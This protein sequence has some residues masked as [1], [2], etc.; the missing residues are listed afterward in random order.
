MAT[1]VIDV[2]E[3]QGVIDWEKVKKSGIKGAI[4]RC[5]Y[6]SDDTSQDDKQ[7]KRNVSECERLGIPYGVYLYSYA[8]NTEMARSEAQHAIRLCKGRK[9]AYPLFFDTEEKGTEN[10]SAACA[11]VFC[12]AVKKAGFTPGIYASRSWWQSYLKGVTGYAKWVAEWGVNKCSITCD[13]WQYA[14]NGKVSGINGAVDMNYCY[15]DYSKKTTSK[16]PTAKTETVKGTAAKVLEV[17]KTQIGQEN[18]TKYGKWYEANVDKNTDNYDFGAY[19]VAWCAMFVSWVF[20]QAGAKCAGIPGAYCPSMLAAAEKAKKTVTA[21]NAKPG[22]V[23]YFDWDGGVSDHVGIVEKNDGAYLHTI[24][25]NTDNGIVARKK[26][27]YSTVAGVVRPDYA[28]ATASTT[29][30]S[31]AKKSV[32]TIAKEVIAGKWGNGW[33]RKTAL[34]AAGY[35][36]D[37]VQAQVNKIM[38]SKVLKVGAKVKIKQGAHQYGSTALFA[39]QVYKTVY[40]VVEIMGNRV[41]FATTT[42]NVV[43]GAVAKKD[44]IVQ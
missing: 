37:K 30:A 36:Y 13:I 28:K 22:D 31:T 44:C 43:I 34:E 5:G 23:V 3:H 18:G 24:E 26:R 27:A 33:N 39:A 1:K 6:G 14:D 29:T 40:K 11:R 17:A 35:D 12:E 15:K 42:N 7:W 4:I 20:N 21:K 32:T 2:S 38:A 10:V 19:G 25:G 41:V 8:A 9:L 16:A